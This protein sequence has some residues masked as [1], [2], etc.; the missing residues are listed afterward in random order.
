MET[1]DHYCIRWHPRPLRVATT[2]TG[3]HGHEK[4]EEEYCTIFADPLGWSGGLKWIQMDFRLIE[5]GEL[6]LEQGDEAFTVHS[7]EED[8]HWITCNDCPLYPLFVDDIWK[9]KERPGCF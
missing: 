8:G 4:D 3:G 5:N 2:I 1:C 6:F 7:S 9:I